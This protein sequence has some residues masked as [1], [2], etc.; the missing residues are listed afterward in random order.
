MFTYDIIISF[1]SEC[2]IISHESYGTVHE[3][4]EYVNYKEVERQWDNI[5]RKLV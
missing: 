2:I 5:D 3:Y 4:E 1:M